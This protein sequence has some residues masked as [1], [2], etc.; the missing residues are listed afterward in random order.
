VAAGTVAAGGIVTLL[1][2]Y[3]ARQ[4]LWF[5]LLVMGV[6]VCLA[7]LF[8]FIEQQSDVGVG[9]Y[10]MFEAVFVTLL[11]L[12]QQAFQL[13]PVGALIGALVGLGNL[14]R[15]SELIV[16]RAAGVSVARVAL[17]AAGAGLLL[18]AGGALLGEVLAPPLEAYA[19]QVRT[20]AKYSNLSFAGRA[21][22]WV[23]DGDRIVSIQQQSADNVFGGV[24]IYVV[25]VGADGRQRLVAL[26]RADRAQLVAGRKWRLGNY[27]DSLL[28][29]DGVATRHLA[30]FDVETGI[31]PE[32]LGAAI[33]NP[34]AL[35]V[36]GLYRYVQHLQANGLESR[37]WEVALWA[38]IAR[39]LSTVLM[40]MLAVPFVF[41]PLRSAGAGSRTVI[42][43]SVG[44]VYFLINRTLE[45]SGDVYGLNPL[46]VAWLPAAL[47]AAATAIAIARVR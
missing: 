7:A 18:F 34:D 14:A 21:G 27:H 30:A 2:R 13:L 29:D 28:G 6:L 17:A 39:S 23:K 36:R 45:N 33:V 40:C 24:Y 20:F 43:I 37:S 16:I 3:L 1:D 44:V 26:A 46:V 47:L 32:F 35:P 12:P 8:V 31:N 9:S 5:T 25:S 22:I 38:R 4:I 19:D 11:R 15:G 41:G 10:G 42:G